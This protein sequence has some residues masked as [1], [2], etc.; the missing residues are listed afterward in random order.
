M[1]D[2]E[3]EVAFNDDGETKDSR[4]RS[5]EESDPEVSETQRRRR[6]K[7]PK[8]IRV[9]NE[10]PIDEKE[11]F[12]IMDQ[13]YSF[14]SVVTFSWMRPLLVIGTFLLYGLVLR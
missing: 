7:N 3:V 1:N 5:N 8:E 6:G 9:V 4:N 14:W 10:Q 11:R 12:S 2:D 13:L